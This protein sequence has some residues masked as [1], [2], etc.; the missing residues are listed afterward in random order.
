MLGRGF[1]MGLEE[2]EIYEIY[3]ILKI[4]KNYKKFE[5]LP[6]FISIIQ[7]LIFF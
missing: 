7:S 1:G 5:I 2:I 3:K 4:Y 6:K